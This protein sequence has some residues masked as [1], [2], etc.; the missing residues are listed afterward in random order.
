MTSYALQMSTALTTT[1]KNS[2]RFVR[3]D[4]FRL[5]PCWELL[6]RFRSSRC[7]TNLFVWSVVV[8]HFAVA[9]FKYRRYISH[10]EV[11]GS[12]PSCNDLLKIIV[13]GF[14]NSSFNIFKC[15]GRGHLVQVIYS[16]IA[17]QFGMLLLLHRFQVSQECCRE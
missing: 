5:N 13:K 7:A 16:T 10:S 2:N 12:I 15:T 11:L 3:H 6:R 9:F 17:F 8:G 1:S 14:T 4:L